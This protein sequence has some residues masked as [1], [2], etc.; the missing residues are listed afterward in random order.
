MSGAIRRERNK[1][2]DWERRVTAGRKHKTVIEFNNE[3]QI[4]NGQINKN[5]KG[6]TK[7]RDFRF[8]RNC[9]YWIVKKN[10][11]KFQLLHR[12]CNKVRSNTDTSS[13]VN[14]RKTYEAGVTFLFKFV[15]T[16]ISFHF[17]FI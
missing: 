15:Y 8:A 17:F 11:Q 1:F 3:N 2:F 12:Q 13:I 16:L 5:T 10:V 14:H 6:Q 9:L 7:C 4:K